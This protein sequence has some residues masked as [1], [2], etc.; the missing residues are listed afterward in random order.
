V[1]KAGALV[2]EIPSPERADFLFVF[3]KYR[4]RTSDA[5]EKFMS[6]HEQQILGKLAALS[7]SQANLAR[8]A[9]MPE[10]ELNKGLKGLEPLSGVK[11]ECLN[12][13]LDDLGKLR[14]DISPFELPA[15][16]SNKLKVLL[17]QYRDGFLVEPIDRMVATGLREALAR[18]RR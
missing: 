10:K 12:S 3:Q 5:E 13:I 11:I 8:L 14:D 6:L 7:I 4:R 17:Q 16:D 1:E 9:E 18:A 15:A 2:L